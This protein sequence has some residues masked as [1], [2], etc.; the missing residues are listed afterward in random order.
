MSLQSAG[1]SVARLQSRLQSMGGARGS[2]ACTVQAAMYCGL[3]EVAG[4]RWL[5]ERNRAWRG[6]DSAG[7]GL[8][9]LAHELR[10]AH[11][12]RERE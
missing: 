4:G 2:G 12:L 7:L 5:A 11:G 6:A 10:N 8:D 3:R 9:G 1:R